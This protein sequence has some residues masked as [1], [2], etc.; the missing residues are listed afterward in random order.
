[1]VELQLQHQ[2]LQCS[3]ARAALLQR[4]EDVQFLILMVQRRG[5]VEVAQHVARCLSGRIVASMAAQIGA[6]ITQQ[7]QRPLH[8]LMAGVEHV[9]GLLEPDAGRAQSGQGDL[10]VHAAFSFVALCARGS[11]L[12]WHGVGSD[13]QHRQVL[14]DRR[15]L[16]TH[17]LPM[18]CQRAKAGKA[19]GALV[20]SQ[21]EEGTQSLGTQR[22]PA[23][24]PRRQPLRGGQ[25]QHVL[26][27]ATSSGAV[28]CKRVG[29]I[30]RALHHHEQQLR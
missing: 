8:A 21:A 2:R 15:S 16:A 9:E 11:A 20:I 29:I 27:R 14:I 7:L 18:R 28:L 25:Q 23:G 24:Q 17:L 13:I 26:Q 3:V 10:R 22:A 5:N 30:V 4:G 1:M 19:D 12:Q 6:Q